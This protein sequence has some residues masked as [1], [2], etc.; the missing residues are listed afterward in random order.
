MRLLS[1]SL[2]LAAALAATPASAQFSL[3]G[4][5]NNLV[6]FALDRLSVPGEF[7]ITAEGL[8]ENAEGVT[9]LR[10]LAIA[11]AEGAW[12]RAEA[13][14]LEWNASR[15]LRGELEIE[16]LAARGVEVL[17]QPEASSLPEEEAPPQEEEAGP[18]EWPR[19]PIDVVVEQLALD[20]VRV[21]PGVIAE[22]GI[23]FDARGSARDEGAVQAADLLIERTDE[24]EGL[25]DLAYERNFETGLLSVDLE[26]DED[27]GGLIAALAGFPA[28][29]GANLTVFADGPL[30]DWRLVFT[31][32]ANRVFSAQG[33]AAVNL[34]A[35]V[36]VSAV[37]TVTP[38][39]A[40]DPQL[41]EALSPLGRLV[42]DAQEDEDGVIRIEQARIASRALSLDADGFYA[43][44][45]GAVE[46]S[47]EVAAEAA[48][49]ALVEGVDWER[50]AFD[51]DVSGALDDL[52]AEGALTLTGLKTAAVDVGEAA[53][54]A[55]VA[56]SGTAIR[57]DVDGSAA[58]L[59]LD[60]LAPETVG[61]A[62]LAAAGA[63][64]DG[65]LML[66]RVALD[67]PL[68]T[69][70]ASGALGGAEGA[71]IA[72][73]LRVPALT[74]VA[75]AYEVEASGAAAVEGTVSGDL[76]APRIAG[77]A[78]LRDLTY[79]SETY[80]RVALEHD[81]TLGQTPQGR[82]ALTADG[83][84]YGPV[85]IATDFR[86][87]EQVL[88]LSGLDAEGLGAR[89][90]GDL[91]YDL[92]TQLAEGA[93]QARIADLAQ[94]GERAGAALTGDAEL[95]IALE[96][97]DGAQTVI[98]EGTGSDVE[99]F[100]ARIEAFAVDATVRDALGAPRG[101]GTAS[102]TGLSAPGV[103]AAE[104]A[105]E[106]EAALE[107]EALVADGV[108]TASGLEAAG[109]SVASLRLEGRGEDLLTAPSA[110]AALTA[111]AI[112]YPEA[113]A[114]IA[115]LRFEGRAADLLDSP[116]ARG[117]LT[118][119]D[120]EA[121]GATVARVVVEGSGQDLIGAPSATATLTAEA[122]AYPEADA[123]VATLR[124]E[125]RAVDLLDSP[126]ARGT[127]TVET[128]EA[129]G[130]TVERVVV[131]GSGE[132]LID[133]P[134]AEASLT[135]TALAYPEAE[136]RIAQLRFEGSGEN[137]AAAPSVRG[138]LTATDLTGAGASAGALR[139]ELA[140]ED[141][142]AAPSGSVDAT[143]ETV[144]AGG[145]RT[146]RIGLQAEL[147]QDPEG[148]RL[149]A[150]LEAAPVVAEGARIGSAAAEAVVEDALSET[151]VIDAEARI[152]DVAAG[153]AEL[154]TLTLDAAGPLAALD[155]A[156]D[157]RGAVAG[158]PLE[159]SLRAR[160]DAAGDTPSAVV[161]RL[162]AALGET[163]VALTAPARLSLADGVAAQGL[164]VAVPGGTLSGDLAYRGGGLVG[165]LD[166][167]LAD[168]RPLSELAGAGLEAG[169][170]QAA[171]RFDTR[172][173]SA[174]ATVDAS[175][176]NLRPE[177]ADLGPRGLDL[178]LDADWNGAR[179]DAEAVATGPF[180]N[181]L[182]ATVALPL[183]P[184]GLIPVAPEG[185]ALDGSVRWR[186]RL[187]DLWALVP[188]PDHILD[189]DAAVDLAFG[190]TLASPEVSGS[191]AL[192]DGTYQYLET[193][194]ILTEFVIDSELT[195]GG[196]IRLRARAA[197]GA[198]GEVLAEALV[199]DG[200][201]RAELDAQEAILVRR[202]DVTAAITLDIEAAGPLT[203]PDIAGEV[204]IERAEVRLVAATPPSVVTLGDVRIKGEPVE[205]AEEAGEAGAIGLDI[206]IRAPND[207]F[208]RGRGLDSEW[209]MALR[210]EGTASNPR[211][212]GDIQRIRGRL[213]LM[214]FPFELERGRV[215]FTGGAEIDPLLDIA[216]LRE[217]D[218][219][220]GGIVVRG[221]AS[222][223][224][225]A[226]ESQPELPEGEVLPRVLFGTSR[227]SLSSG[228]AIQLATGI[229]T[230]LGGGGG[231]VDAIRSAA[232]L[233]V[234]RF[235]QDD[236][237]AGV[238]VGR[239]LSDDVFVGARQPIEG[240]PATAR[241]EIEV[242]ENLS[243]DTEIGAEA[244]SSLG[245]SWKKD[246]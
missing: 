56:R 110:T 237:G 158:E 141:L 221:R 146:A 133:A 100:D 180:E 111:E 143:L 20:G 173:G 222:D 240:G 59:R 112:A 113:D 65:R 73:A 79:Q 186:G 89:I 233:D 27:A 62:E 123:R 97:E 14:S 242:F 191:V 201:L 41:K 225:I 140:A 98:V 236:S 159:A 169:S 131:E 40:L 11:D 61:Q 28:D 70:E 10:G 119:D 29:A 149:A 33:Q 51:G 12:L 15:I 244:G 218:G 150:A 121:A 185:G 148:A 199:E 16:R 223:P 77:E 36:A 154:A 238:T 6:Q 7:E 32:G 60:R 53:L 231:P 90:A 164:R 95:R 49:A 241:V 246:F 176:R 101:R 192:A 171:A 125:G 17:R 26:T 115:T 128:I 92:E 161:S 106:G 34:T 78:A 107:G 23:A 156:L 116:E 43:R 122:I 63:F 219:V 72:Y 18:F 124:F 194:T 155:L 215:Q 76:A 214:G 5:Q 209:E 87:A 145:A 3:L 80:G 58:G 46:L 153:G 86:L 25:I 167:S 195:P 48:L 120:V 105:F 42:V 181:P 178:A 109:A 64:D 134:S 229:A 226:F 227:Q 193:G 230:L 183:R 71:G 47:L 81:V 144:E 104:A 67:S 22:Q 52:T 205:D 118:L 117:T 170:A 213:S 69:L 138:V 243:A 179:L 85:E 83:S 130:A 163:A 162:R 55:E 160:A 211:V 31:A 45:S 187:G 216:L 99:G 9:E 91:S 129:A 204:V 200:R 174:F 189:G 1:L 21:A 93:V 175:A 210:V 96:A 68:L 74:P 224:E 147:A 44:E 135:A 37:A 152:A 184:T 232:G 203:A 166:L 35:P 84:A 235:D 212:I 24:V 157:A 8:E 239:N 19:A 168:V 30:D 234:L 206:A 202:D 38:G 103:A 2:G 190:G 66:E 126:E 50:V 82:V 177:Q 151:P 196:G 39:E 75:E 137:L 165:D 94:L 217:N 132:N 207:V 228:Q 114:R 13:V 208:V 57:F 108:L 139:A 4:L 188:A 172:A 102:V 88:A 197:D 136:A 198:G 245:L 127:L 182:V 54:Q 142:L 220:T